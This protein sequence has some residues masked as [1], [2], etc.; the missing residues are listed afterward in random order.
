MLF[1][2]NEFPRGVRTGICDSAGPDSPNGGR[3]MHWHS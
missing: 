2:P 1:L 3:D